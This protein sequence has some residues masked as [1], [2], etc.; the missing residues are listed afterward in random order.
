MR[1]STRFQTQSVVTAFLSITRSRMLPDLPK[2]L[3]ACCVDN[4][5]IFLLHISSPQC[6]TFRLR[7]YP[8][9][10]M[11]ALLRGNVQV[12]RLCLRRPNIRCW[13]LSVTRH[14][15]LPILIQADVDT[16]IF[17]VFQLY[18]TLSGDGELLHYQICHDFVSTGKVP[19]TA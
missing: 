9:L 3:E 2:R 12:S 4:I 7:P 1:H 18:P 15:M 16:L 10:N 11:R 6:F 14:Q 8:K 13:L 19:A 17:W 5:I